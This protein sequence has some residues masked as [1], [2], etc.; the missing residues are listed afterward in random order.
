LSAARDLF[1]AFALVGMLAIVTVL[2]MQPR[3]I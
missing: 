2:M 1:L 3:L